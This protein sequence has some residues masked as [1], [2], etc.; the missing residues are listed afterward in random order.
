M[1]TKSGMIQAHDHIVVVQKVHDAFMIKARLSSAL[2]PFQLVLTFPATVACQGYGCRSERLHLPVFK[3]MVLADSLCGPRGCW[4]CQHTAAV[5]HRHDE[6]RKPKL[7]FGLLT[8]SCT[9]FLSFDQGNAVP[10]C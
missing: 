9:W 3:A 6:G 4:N 2:L 10:L 1:C 7:N 5:P 8:S